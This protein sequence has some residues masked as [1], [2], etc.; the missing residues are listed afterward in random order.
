M[1]AKKTIYSSGSLTIF[2]R[3]LLFITMGCS[4]SHPSPPST[5]PGPAVIISANPENIEMVPIPTQNPAQQYDI[6]RADLVQALGHV[7]RYL[8]DNNANITIIGI[9]GV[10]NTVLLGSRD[11]THDVD[12]FASPDLNTENA[13]LLR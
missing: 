2:N 11:T 13:Q 8:Q 3:H 9:G 4:S 10:V 12:F 1:Y 7:A 5:P 6:S